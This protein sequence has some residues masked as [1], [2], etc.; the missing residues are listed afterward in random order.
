[1]TEQPILHAQGKTQTALQYYED[2]REL[3]EQG[4]NLQALNALKEALT[5]DKNLADAYDLQ[6][7]MLLER[8]T[9]YDWSQ[10][11]KAAQKASPTPKIVR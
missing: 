2:A 7:Q 10:S 9:E 11:Q 4:Q 5:L 1:M 6:A 3:Y 8:D